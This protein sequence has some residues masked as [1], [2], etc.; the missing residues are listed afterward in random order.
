MLLHIPQPSDG[1]R[2]YKL[3][4]HG[5]VHGALFPG[6]MDSLLHAR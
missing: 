4:S 2:E 3:L 6:D 1:S 5:Y